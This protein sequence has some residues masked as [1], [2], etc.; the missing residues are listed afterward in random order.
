MDSG[1]ISLAIAAQLR[2]VPV[3]VAQ[4]AH[5]FPPPEGGNTIDNLQRAARHTGFKAKAVKVD[6]TAI[7]PRILPAIG[8]GRNNRFFT[9]ARVEPGANGDAIFLIQHPDSTAPDRLSAAQMS[10]MAT[11]QVL[12]LRPLRGLA[13]R[14]D[15]AFSLRWFIPS[16]HKYRRLFAEV[17]VA[18]FALQLFALATPL[19][20]QVVMDK[21]LVHRGFSTLNVLAAGFAVVVIFDAVIGGLRNYLFSHTSHRVDVELG[22]RLFR[23]LTALPLAYFE[24]RQVGHSVAR[25]RELETIRSFIT[26]TALTLIIDLAFTFVFVAVLWYYSP[27]LTWIVL[28]SLPFYLLLSACVTP[29][30]RHRLDEKFRAGATNQAFLTETVAGMQTVKAQALEPQMQRRWE[31]QLADYVSSAFRAQNLNNIASQAAGLISKLTTLLIVFWGAHLVIAGALTVGQLVAFNMIAGRISGPILKLVQLWQDFQQA[32]ISLQRLGD[33]LN[34]PV[35]AGASSTLSSPDNLSGSVRFDRVRFRYKPG[36]PLVLDEFELNVPAGALI[37]IVGRSGSGKSTLA[38]LLQRLYLPEAGRVLV[39]GIDLAM[40]DNAWLRRN[41]GL[42][43]QESFLFNRSVRDNI[44]LSLPGTSLERVVQCA[45]AAGAHEFILDLPNAYDTVVEEQGCNLSGGQR[46]RIA[47]AR[48]L[49]TD[50]KI[51]V[52]DEATSA[53]DYESERTVQE[54]MGAICQGRTV[55]IIAHRLS[56]VRH[57]DRIVVLDQGRVSES[58]THEHLLQRNGYYARLY[59]YQNHSP[60]MRG[61]ESGDPP[62]KDDTAAQQASRAPDD[63]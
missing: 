58:G 7:E 22:A 61:I 60:V 45:R 56:T 8:L 34:T 24:H 20:F 10:H 55:F 50:P 57:C 53:L 29:M 51:L 5:R 39:D 63:S 62:Q 9:I 19:F 6:W 4:L 18:S 35:E 33:I 15:G 43:Q 31:E 28:G 14:S 2:D 38:K 13:S 16:I 42:V 11:T 37:G 21:V 25:V 52:M 32:G 27:T 59:S 3:N 12:L 36:S 47:I 1:F 44:A 41:V 40:V 48:A 46:Q 17:L 54:N 23:H 26:G 49:L 30:L